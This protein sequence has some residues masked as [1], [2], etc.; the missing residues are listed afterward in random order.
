MN[1]LHQAARR[2][3]REFTD[4]KIRGS[5]LTSVSRLLSRIGQSGGIPVLVLPLDGPLAILLENLERPL[6]RLRA[7]R[8]MLLAQCPVCH[9]LFTGASDCVV[10]ALPCGHVFHKHCVDTWFRTAVT[11]PQCRVQVKRMNTIIRLYFDIVPFP[12]TSSQTRGSTAPGGKILS[13]GRHSGQDG[14]DIELYRMRAEKTRLEEE[15]RQAERRAEENNKLAADRAKEIATISAL[16]TESDKLCEKERQRCRDLRAELMSMKQFLRDAESMKAEAVKLRAEMEGMQNIQK[17]IAAS[18]EAAMDLL[19]RYRSERDEKSLK[20]VDREATYGL[21][22]LC[23]WTAV[24]RSELTSAREKARSYRIELSRVRKLYQ[25]ASQRAS[26][27]EMMVAKKDK[28]INSLEKELTSAMQCANSK[29]GNRTVDTSTNSSFRLSANPVDI[30]AA[31]DSFDLF[32]SRPSIASLQ[33]DNPSSPILDTPER[34][35]ITPQA[36]TTVELQKRL[37]TPFE[38]PFRAKETT[39]KNTKSICSPSNKCLSIDQLCSTSTPSKMFV[40]N[41]PSTSTEPCKL[42]RRPSVLLEM[43]IMRR[44]LSNRTTQPTGVSAASLPL[45]LAHTTVRKASERIPPQQS[46]MKWLTKRPAPTNSKKHADL[47]TKVSRLDRFLS[48]S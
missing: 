34:L 11:C 41:K 22:T 29:P 48:K 26:R 3:E 42:Q 31:Q 28:Q 15:L 10:S 5:N 9:E 44:H 20:S 4:R 18:E 35:A 36:P 45:T 14:L 43:A 17:L 37:R 27:F 38:N 32:S 8:V 7:I 19:S 1:V 33:T 13:P 23:R 40:S 25:T 24:L 12:G 16:Y 6:R 39:E 47:K 21:E 2:S 46:H 30:D